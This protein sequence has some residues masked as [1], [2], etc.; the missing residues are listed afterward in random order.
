MHSLQDTARHCECGKCAL[1][2]HVKSDL[3]KKSVQQRARA[4][5]TL[6]QQHGKAAT[7]VPT[8]NRA[9]SKL[10]DHKGFLSPNHRGFMLVV[11]LCQL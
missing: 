3:H 2:S 8:S 4:S 11:G 6:L 7:R 10:S 1:E 5:S 9:I